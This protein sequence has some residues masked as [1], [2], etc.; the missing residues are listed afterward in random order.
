MSN[1]PAVLGAV[2]L[3]VGASLV[4]GARAATPRR[5]FGQLSTITGGARSER[6][7]GTP[8]ADV[9]DGGAGSDTSLGLGGDDRICGGFGEDH[10][11]GGRGD[12]RVAGGQL[13]EDHLVGG[14]GDDL[15]DGGGSGYALVTGGDTV[16]Y[17]DASGPVVV[18]LL[19]GQAT[20]QGRDTL[21]GFAAIDGSRFADTLIGGEAFNG[22][23][24]RG[25]GGADLI[26]GYDGE[27][28]NGDLLLGGRGPDRLRGLGGFDSLG[29][30]PGDDVLNGGSNIEGW[31]VGL[32]GVEFST[33]FTYQGSS[34]PVSADLSSGVASGEGR[35]ILSGLEGLTGSNSDDVLVGD[36]QSNFLRGGNFYVQDSGAD[37]LRALEG[38][39]V[40]AFAD[41]VGDDS[42]YGGPGQDDCQ[43]DPSDFLA[44]CENTS[45]LRAQVATPRPGQLER[46]MSYT[47]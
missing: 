8:A 25:F 1:R 22:N 2:A 45:T 35:D 18:D 36:P 34:G 9:I 38:D 40:I 28:S 29:G 27:S 43:A 13:P 41:G 39:D 12:D 20:G 5:C 19:T 44:S 11:F 32:Y 6:L 24:I 4:S 23:A 21:A 14:A 30:G 16:S 26:V 47:S 10:L 15:L 31:D 3:V 17:R 42:G 37:T 46:L 33:E 7:V